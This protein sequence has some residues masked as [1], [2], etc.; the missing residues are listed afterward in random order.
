M[1]G[2]RTELARCGVDTG[3][4]PSRFKWKV[5]RGLGGLEGLK[6]DPAGQAGLGRVC[7]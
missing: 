5:Y 1:I 7:G 2:I 6:A 4:G 3:E